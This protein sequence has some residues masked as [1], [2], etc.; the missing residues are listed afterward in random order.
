MVE[1][2]G[3]GEIMPLLNGIQCDKI[4]LMKINTPLSVRVSKK[5][6]FILNLNNYRNAHYQTLNKAKVEFA[7]EMD[8][9]CPMEVLRFPGQVE[10]KYTVFAK[11]KRRFDIGNVCSVVQKFFEDWLIARGGLEDDNVKF[12]PRVVYEYG[13][14]DKED[15]R[16][17]IE[18][19][20]VGSYGC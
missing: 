5:K 7:N 19:K 10:I 3:E 20:E 12:I 1:V 14:V 11:T 16:V 6:M 17:E 18:I 4:L 9:R 15:P 13:G 8:N 2:L